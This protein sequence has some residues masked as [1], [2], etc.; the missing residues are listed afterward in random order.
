MSSDLLGPI[1]PVDREGPVDSD[2][3]RLRSG[4]SGGGLGGRSGHGSH[5][6]R[7]GRECDSE[8]HVCGHAWDV[9]AG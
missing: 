6:Q 9:L 7:A 4:R 5:G 1:R 2:E 3:A 8:G